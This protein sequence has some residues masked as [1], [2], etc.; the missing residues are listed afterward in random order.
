MKYIYFILILIYEVISYH[1]HNHNKYKSKKHTLQLMNESRMRLS[2]VSIKSDKRFQ[3]FPQVTYDNNL[4]LTLGGVH[5]QNWA[6]YFTLTRADGNKMKQFNINNGFYNEQDSAFRIAHNDSNIT[7]PEKDSFF[8][9]LTD[10]Y[11][12]VLSS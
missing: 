9:I 3:G 4:K 11:I 8:F 6:K 5:Y 10:Y 7:I 2:N 1:S 12:C